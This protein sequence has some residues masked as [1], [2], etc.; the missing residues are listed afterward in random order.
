MK[1]AGFTMI[2]LIFVIVILGILAAV[3]LPKF[4]GVAAQAQVGKVS[5]YVG[6]LNR[7]TAPALWALSLA[8]KDN[9]SIIPA[10][11]VTE[12][13]KQIQVPQDVGDTTA[14]DLTALN[15]AAC[16]IYAVP[17]DG[18][19][20]TDAEILKWG[21]VS[22]VTIDAIPYTVVC[23]DGSGTESPHFALVKNAAT[24]VVR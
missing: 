19:Q 9:G 4:V 1:R 11:Y 24:V 13:A 23:M 18:S 10:A 8:N 3:A 7:T 22:T 17:A 16:T 21:T 20:Y 5:A 2:E 15:T 12:A 6:T 14:T